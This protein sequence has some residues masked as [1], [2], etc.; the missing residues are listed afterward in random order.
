MPT[1]LGP[2]LNSDEFRP[3]FDEVVNEFIAKGQA[4]YTAILAGECFRRMPCT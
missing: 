2:A 4:V 1:P 3:S